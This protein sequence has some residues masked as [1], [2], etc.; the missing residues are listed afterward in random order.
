MKF[1]D[2]SCHV[3]W[4]LNLFLYGAHGLNKSFYL[5][6]ARPRDWKLIT[7]KELHRTGPYLCDLFF[8][9]KEGLMCSDEL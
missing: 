3:C 8:I 7:V 1:E 2:R 9:R 6:A 5:L 4:V